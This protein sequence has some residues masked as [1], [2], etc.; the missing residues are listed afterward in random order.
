M[1]GVLIWSTYV[2]GSGVDQ[3]YSIA[4]DLNDHIFLTGSTSSLDFPLLD[5][6]GGCYFQNTHAGG[7]N[8][9]FIIHFSNTGEMVWSTYYGGNGSDDGLS[10]ITDDEGNLVVTGQTNSSDLPV[11]DAGGD[12]FFQS[13]YGG[14]GDVFILKFTNTGVPI[15]ASYFGGDTYEWHGLSYDKLAVDHC[16]N[17]YLSLAGGPNPYLQAPCDG[18]FYDI[19]LSNTDVFLVMFSNTCKLNWSSFFGGS[20]LDFRGALALDENNNLYVTGE[21]TDISDNSATYP[22]ANPGGDTFYDATFNGGLDDGF[23]AKFSP[24]P[25]A[26]TVTVE[27]PNCEEPCSGSATVNQNTTCALSYLWS[28]GQTNETAIG[29][30]SGNYT[31]EINITTELC[32]QVDT[33][34]SIEI[35]AQMEYVT[36]NFDAVPSICIGETIAA[37]PTTS[38]NDING[39]W[40][41]ALN[42]TETTL[43]TFTPDD[44]QCVNEAEMWIEVLPIL[45]PT[46][47]VI[48]L[49]C[50]DDEIPA[51][52]LISTNNITG[53]WSPSIDNTTT[54]LYTCM[55]D[56]HQCATDTS[57]MITISTI[58]A[59]FTYENAE[60]F[61][62]P[63]LQFI[64]QSENAISYLWDFQ[65][66]G[67]STL[68]E[69]ALK[70]P[71]SNFIN[72]QACLLA[73]N[74]EGCTDE[75]CVNLV[76]ESEIMLYVPNA[77]TPDGDGINDFFGPVIYGHDPSAFEF[78]I[79]NRW[80]DVIFSSK[81]AE[82]KW[83]GSVH[84]GDFFSPDGVYVWSIKA[85]KI[86]AVETEEFMGH[87]TLVR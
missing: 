55:P 84:N 70:I 53:T 73:S 31:V 71:E 19:L 51:L 24:I 40:S 68:A 47:N 79:F 11:F 60:N 3:G 46:F 1:N 12:S 10:L 52:P 15:W 48:D 45:V 29:L 27:Q 59:S 72:M 42:A 22:L 39:T 58:A 8:D 86:G 36:P 9:A 50:E 20:S 49:F 16:G 77:L 80:G 26:T 57:V 18:G 66:L 17:I 30:C 82:K 38:L 37:L 65:S 5:A 44:A 43:Y 25:I 28:D 62:S 75:V 33:T 63:H 76:F 78:I 56:D 74:A 35:P 61:S 14:E 81:D 85:K 32:V 54:T 41:P 21:W 69:P 83:D 6:G 87:V 23:M 2:G 34:L 13:T 67:S 7:N 4:T 64:N